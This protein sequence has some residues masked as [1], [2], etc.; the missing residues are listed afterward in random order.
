MLDKLNMRPMVRLVKF[1]INIF[2]SMLLVLGVFLLIAIVLSF[3]DYPYWAYY[4]L[5]TH[6]SEIVVKPNL[7]VL[8]GGGGMPSPDGLMR[9]YYASDVAKKYK[10]SAIIIALPPDTSLH[11]KSPEL[12]LADELKMRGVDSIRIF[13]EREGNNT[14][15]QATN[16]A[17]MFDKK[18][19]DT[20]S[21]H[22]V[23]SPEHMYRSVMVFRKAGFQNVGG[24]PSF[25]KSIE[26]R[27]LL[28]KKKSG[29]V[30]DVESQQLNLRYNMWNYL[31]YE[32]T[33]MRE[34]TAIAY[35]KIRGWI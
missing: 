14:F 19:I 29:K 13:Y 5:G 30:T 4:W 20:I 17:D 11:E 26:E 1:G 32:I 9:G 33:V 27:M 23:T 8:L 3:T 18:F 28:K 21:I 15:S 35:Y 25:E 16:I 24:M 31:K 6:N 2:R 7:I 12:M 34:Y 10:K 22:I